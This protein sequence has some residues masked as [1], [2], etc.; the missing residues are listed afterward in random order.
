M[1]AAKEICGE[2]L[3]GQDR[4]DSFHPRTCEREAVE[5]VDGKKYCKRH[6][7]MHRDRKAKRLKERAADRA[8]DAYKKLV[9]QLAED[10]GID[11]QP[12]YRSFRGGY[13]HGRVDI[14]IEAAAKLLRGAK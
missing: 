10:T 3:Q 9:A 2:H 13:D 12:V 8:D 5:E 14:P 6:A 7:K 4:W 1:A 11:M